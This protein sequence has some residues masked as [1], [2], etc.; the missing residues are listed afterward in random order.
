M[1]RGS[2]T[3]IGFTAVLMWALLAF[4]TIGTAPVPP[5][6]LNAICFAL[7]G[8]I[9]L[10]W[11]G[12]GRGFGVL[13][14]VSWKVYAFGTLGLFG[15]HLL[16]FSAFR[17]APYAQTGLIAYLWPLFIVICSGLLP[18]ERLRPLHLAGAGLAFAGA[19]G[20]VL[21]GGQGMGPGAALGFGLAFLC[22]L[23]WAGYSVLSRLMG[24]VPTEA[25]TVFCLMT[26]L[27][28][29]VTHLA[30]EETV[31]PAATAG[32][33]SIAALGLGPV[34]LAFFTWDVGMKRGDIQMLG[35]LSYAAPLLSTLVLVATGHAALSPVLGLS[36]LAITG[37]AALAAR[38]GGKEVTASAG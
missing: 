9:G 13:R 33:L 2:A 38:A 7:G 1:T 28:S 27:L 19:A 24:E 34:G 15:Y 37:G 21:A 32:W 22:A 17:I 3:L 14:Q 29:A 31:W 23:T 8:A 35:T 30:L 25:V 26:A 11:M 4:L 10:L 6:Q 18:G 16:Y 5:L 12:F 20:I 36:A